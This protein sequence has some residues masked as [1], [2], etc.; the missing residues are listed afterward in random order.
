[1]TFDQKRSMHMEWRK[2]T[3]AKKIT[4]IRY[5][6]GCLVT[7]LLIKK[8][9]NENKLKRLLSLTVNLYEAM[10]TQ[11]PQHYLLIMN[12]IRSSV[13][14]SARNQLNQLTDGINKVQDMIFR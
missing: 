1:M 9:L 8:M 6:L 5:E 12:L 7:T 3:S 2:E 14:G 11:L 4:F 10:E 13:T